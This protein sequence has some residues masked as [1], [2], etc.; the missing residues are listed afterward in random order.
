MTAAKEATWAAIAVSVVL[1]Q[2]LRNICDCTSGEGRRAGV[3]R[4]RCRLFLGRRDMAF[5]IYGLRY[6]LRENETNL[7]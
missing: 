1:V 7:H 5:G 3:P 2:S 4:G 6:R